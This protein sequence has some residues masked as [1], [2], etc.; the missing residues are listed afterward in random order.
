MHLHSGYRNALT[1]ELCNLGQR[2]SSIWTDSASP[3][4]VL[5]FQKTFWFDTIRNTFFWL[6]IENIKIVNRN[7]SGLSTGLNIMEIYHMQN[8]RSTF[9]RRGNYCWNA[10]FSTKKMVHILLSVKA[11]RIKFS[12]ETEPTKNGKETIR[13]AG[14]RL[15]ALI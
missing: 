8:T 5:T 6:Q 7:C 2:E 11:N 13:L 12:K 3:R 15:G 4:G 14:S 1:T 10:L 9:K